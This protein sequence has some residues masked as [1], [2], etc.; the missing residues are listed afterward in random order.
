MWPGLLRRDVRI[1]FNDVATLLWLLLSGSVNESGAGKERSD[2]KQEI[3]C[4]LTS[5]MNGVVPAAQLTR[6]VFA[7]NHSFE[8]PVKRRYT[9]TSFRTNPQ[10]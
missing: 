9:P 8:R 5:S 7:A 6:H 10:P 1:V 4:H 2:G 3:F